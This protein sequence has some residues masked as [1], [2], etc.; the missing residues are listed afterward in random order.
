MYKTFLKIFYISIFLLAFAFSAKAKLNFHSDQDKSNYV[1]Y[2]SVNGEWPVAILRRMGLQPIFGK[3]GS[4]VHYFNLNP[5][6]KEKFETVK[7]YNFPD[8]VTMYIP[9]SKVDYVS[10][11]NNFEIKNG[12][13]VFTDRL[14]DRRANDHTKVL[15]IKRLQAFSKNKK[16]NRSV[17]SAKPMVKKP[18][19]LKVP[20]KLKANDPMLNYDFGVPVIRVPVAVNS[21]IYKT[22]QQQG[23]LP[24]NKATKET[25]YL[26]IPLREK[27]NNDWM[28]QPLVKAVDG[29]PR[30]VAA[31]NTSKVEATTPSP[32]NIEVKTLAGSNQ[33]SVTDS[34]GQAGDI[35][36]DPSFGFQL[37]GAFEYSFLDIESRLQW[38]TEQFQSDTTI[39]INQETDNRLDFR[40]R[41][42]FDLSWLNAFF[43]AGYGTSAAFASTSAT[44][45]QAKHL[46]RPYVHIGFQKSFR[47]SGS[48]TSTFDISYDYLLGV[49]DSLYKLENG[50]RAGTYLLNNWQLS[51]NLYFSGD[52]GI[53]YGDDS[54]STYEQTYL[55]LQ[56]LLGVQWQFGNQ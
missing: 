42:K 49:E 55:G 51:Q 32:F 52:L 17:A 22:L 29:K 28:K 9:I 53:L 38:Q 15:N 5:R 26:D 54:P 6:L 45:L 2:E 20:K 19:K 11:K 36:I 30:K 40:L 37:G 50:Y 35:G 12:A 41:Q 14:K 10:E 43:G 27:P 47:L 48:V 18:V 8:G 39:L 56:L 23:F 21:G 24:L 13:L 46:N 3:N 4:L 34:N 7:N 44:Q 31:V 33:Y 1:I 25:V 16:G